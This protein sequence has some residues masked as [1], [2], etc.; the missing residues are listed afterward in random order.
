MSRRGRFRSRP[1]LVT[2]KLLILCLAVLAGCGQKKTY[3]VLGRL[4]LKGNE[5]RQALTGYTVSLESTEQPVSAV[6]IV[7]SDGT[8]QLTTFTED[9]GAVPG[10][11]RIAVSAPQ[12]TLDVPIPRSILDKRYA[13][14]ETS[15]LETVIKAGANELVLEL[16][17]TK[18][19]K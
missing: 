6:G 12:P 19:K 9:D 17:P 13:A 18:G 11:H 1:V 10:K 15:G 16:D 4:T 8:F 3:P 14:F 2:T 5:G 7:Q